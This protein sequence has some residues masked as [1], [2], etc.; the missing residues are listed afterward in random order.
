MTIEK[1]FAIGKY[2]VTRREFEAFIRETGRDMGGDCWYW[3]SEE[4]KPQKGGARSWRKPG[5]EQTDLDPVVCVS[6]EDAKMYV[7]W[8]SDKT[9]KRYRLPS[10]SEWEYAA[11]GKSRTSR[12]W[13]DDASVQCSHANGADETLKTRYSNLRWVVASCRDG[14][15]HTAPVG[16]LLVNGFGLHGRA[17]QRL[18]VGCGLPERALRGRALRWERVDGRYLPWPCASRWFL[19]QQTEFP[20][21]CR[22][23]LASFTLTNQH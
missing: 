21:H 6:W 12:Y 15:V 19:E 1:P 4:S 10:E 23:L 16:S 11:R 9:G 7:E 17:G 20:A 18:G 22:S 8:L 14:F 13:G 3:D 5:F 2:E